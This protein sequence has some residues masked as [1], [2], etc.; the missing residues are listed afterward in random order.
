MHIDPQIEVM[1]SNIHLSLSPRPPTLSQYIF[2]EL[3][4]YLLSLTSFYC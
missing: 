4:R 1:Q 3:K 2:E